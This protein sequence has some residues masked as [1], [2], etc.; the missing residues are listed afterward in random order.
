[1]SFRYLLDENVPTTSTKINNKSQEKS[2]KVNIKTLRNL[3]KK[4]K[5]F[6]I[7]KTNFE[8]SKKITKPRS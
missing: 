3:G 4:F 8:K 7:N 1:M 2:P 6:E 5:R